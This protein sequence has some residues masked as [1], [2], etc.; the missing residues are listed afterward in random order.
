MGTSLVVLLPTH[1]RP[2]LLARTLDTIAACTRPEGYGGCLVV[3]NGT[4]S[5]AEV[6]VSTATEAHPEAGFR[7]LHHGRAN[8]S[9]ALNAALATVASDSLCV[10]F[11]DDI[12]V[13]P[14]ALMAYAEEARRHP[15][16]DVFF[17]GPFGIDYEDEP[18]EWVR[19]LLPWSAKGA[20]AESIC[21]SNMFMGF[22]WAVVASAILDLGGFDPNFGPGSP[23]GA[24]GQESNMQNRLRASGFSAVCVPGALVWHHV[25]TSRSGFRWALRRKYKGGLEWGHR[26]S[27]PLDL[28][29]VAKESVGAIGRLAWHGAKRDKARAAV[30][31]GRL[32]RRFGAIRGYWFHK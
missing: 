27:S 19:Q 32:A 21:R 18:P 5:G 31:V 22:N 9:A 20:D 11:D 15:G 12:R 3:E 24:T 4:P 29:V 23:T 6:V 30:Q 7:Y 26:L 8:K 14:S 17:G 1:G 13:E 10:F 16:R 28:A 2:T 25:P